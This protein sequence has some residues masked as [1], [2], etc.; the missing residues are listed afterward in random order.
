MLEEPKTLLKTL[1]TNTANCA[2][3]F[4]GHLTDAQSPTFLS[5]WEK[6]TGNPV[7]EV[8][9]MVSKKPVCTN[10]SKNKVSKRRDKS[11]FEYVKGH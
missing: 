10:S 6:V 2:Q 4:I 1:R 7:Q 9:N 11:A 3:D 8:T 5:L